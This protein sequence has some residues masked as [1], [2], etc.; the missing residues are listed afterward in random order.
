MIK[1][2]VA[3]QNPNPPAPPPPHPLP[4]LA[5][6]PPKM[7]SLSTPTNYEQASGSTVLVLVHGP[8]GRG[9]AVLWSFSGAGDIVAHSG[10]TVQG[11]RGCST[12][13]LAW[14]H[15]RA[16]T[17][18][19]FGCARLVKR[20]GWCQRG[21]SLQTAWVEGCIKPRQERCVAHVAPQKASIAAA[22]PCTAALSQSPKE[23]G[24]CEADRL[25]KGA[26]QR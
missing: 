23:R 8:P 13:R 21:L 1:G 9:G 4:S 19:A 11:G 20:L 15:C 25:E 3:W 22:E 14:L 7:A 6:F 26:P 17:L 16:R 2:L 24:P 18:A 10:G 5:H 12:A